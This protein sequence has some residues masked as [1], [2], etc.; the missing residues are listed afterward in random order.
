MRNFDTVLS[1][2]QLGSGRR[3]QTE[4][5]LRVEL[6][7]TYRL[8]A[9]L[10]WDMMIFGHI[11]VKVPGS[12]G[13]FLINPFG[14]RF[15]EVTASNLVKID[16]RANIVEPSEYP[17]NPAGFYIHSA[18]HE[19]REDAFCVMHTHTTAGMAMAAIEPELMP[20]DFAGANI[21]GRI[22]YHAFAGVHADESDCPALVAS[23]GNRNYL[24]LRN[25]GLLTC[26]S[27]IALAFQRLF[28]L[29]TACRVQSTALAMN[30]PVRRI[31]KDVIV[32]HADELDRYDGQLS[33]AAM[34]RL[35]EKLDPSFKD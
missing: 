17:V 13:H 4:R 31:D 6:A 20:I 30:A 3:A 23:L 2:Q 1:M 22:G 15:D 12:P 11:T 9:H 5:E 21:A 14:L 35:M 24:M 29:E 27:S 18:V 19:A 25:H 8:F 10:G 32:Q 7:G 34:L 33:L 28:W 16:A 26:G